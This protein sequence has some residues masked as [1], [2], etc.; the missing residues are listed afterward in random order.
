[1]SKFSVYLKELL[2]ERGEP[3]ARVAKNIGIERTSIH[4][5]LKDERIL[6]YTA[7]KQ[8][9]R[10]FQL[11]LPQVR[12]LNQYYEMLLQG[13]DIYRIQEAICELLSELSQLHFS[14]YH[15]IEQETAV[16][17]LNSMPGLIHGKHQVESTIQTIFQWEAE[18]SECAEMILY[19]P[20]DCSL[21]DSLVRLWQNGRKFTARQIVAFLPG[22]SGTGTK[23]ENLH[24]L[25]KLLP[26]S[27]VSQGNYFA[28]YYFEENTSPSR[29]NPLAYYIVTPHFLITLD[30]SLS[31][32]Q[33][34]TDSKV[35]QLY[36]RRFNQIQ[37]ECQ[38][39][40]SYLNDPVHILESYMQSTDEEGYYTLMAQP[41]LGLY[42]TRERIERQVRP[43][44]PSREF[45]VEASDRRF[46]R[47]RQ[48]E[49]NY[50]TVFSEE[51]LRQLARDGVMVDLPSEFVMPFDIRLRRELFQEMRRDI[52]ENK[53]QCCLADTEKLP[54]PPYLTF[55][56]DPRFGV[57]I[58]AIQG[59]VGGVYACNIHIGEGSIGQSFCE[60]IKSLPN[61]KFVYPKERLLEILDELIQGLEGMQRKENGNHA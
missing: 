56:C 4:K 60:F 30:Y 23:I 26:L 42:Y 45:L 3:I 41:C 37:A 32:A 27:L 16:L 55:T 47:L 13:E 18:A 20:A 6:S 38:P 46:G 7:V 12:E 8:L 15:H 50:Y 10:Y 31:A 21:T 24:L 54:I 1:M 61:S 22:H 40:T 53:I 9:A 25:K 34:Q 44:I 17:D 58:Y 52:Q 11:T 48:L 39:L 57:H 5:A 28:Y 2:D 33:I 29:T 14:S 51:G 43:E 36:E 49:G 19:L 59:F 35:L